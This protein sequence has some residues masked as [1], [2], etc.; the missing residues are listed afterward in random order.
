MT[1]NNTVDMD[2]LLQSVDYK[3]FNKYNLMVL[4]DFYF[5]YSEYNNIS[6]LDGIKLEEI[7]RCALLKSDWFLS[8]MSSFGDISKRTLYNKLK[9][10]E[11]KTHYRYVLTNNINFK[12]FTAFID[13]VL[14][15][16][17]YDTHAH[18]DSNVLC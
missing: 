13:A 3:S 5:N 4:C 11:D 8:E 16:Y 10:T 14:M 18:K 12:T 9:A 6:R 1:N 2:T 15:S 17:I 7:F